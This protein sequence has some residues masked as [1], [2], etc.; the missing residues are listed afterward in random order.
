MN[1]GTAGNYVILAKSGISVVP[2]SKITGDIAVSPAAA[3]YITGFSLIADSTK[4]FA[5]CPQVTGK[6]AVEAEPPEP[7]T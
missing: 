7:A 6:E 3:T 2:T 1:L 4:A 5:T